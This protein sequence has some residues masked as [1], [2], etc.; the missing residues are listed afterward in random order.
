M[1][2]LEGRITVLAALAARRRRIQLVL[3]S[4]AAHR[5]KVRDVE[6]S[7]ARCGVPVKHVEPSELDR[8]THGR[9]H[10]GVVALAG[11]RPPTP[12]DELLRVLDASPVPA[13]LLLLEGLEDA[14]TLGFTLRTAEALGAHGVLVK[15]HLWDYDA[16]DVSRSSS[17][18]YERLPL[19]QVDQTGTVIGA[20]RKRGV[21]VWGC[22]AGARR[23]IHDVD[24]SRPSLL[25]IGGEKRGLS[26]ALRELCD[27]FLSIPMGAVE[28][29]PE[30]GEDAPADVSRVT[31]LSLGHAAA[32]VMAEVLRQ[33]RPR[34]AGSTTP[35]TA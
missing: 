4:A 16:A 9:T 30:E 25:A 1:E 18:A 2:H 5:E 14:Q 31:S 10:G 19:V 20:L 34:A 13:F 17:G 12:V 26:G 21:A 3:I 27:G 35:S 33:R 15:K 8:M 24:L 28:N 23:T 11:P 29:G 32:I 7:A 6:A 22:L